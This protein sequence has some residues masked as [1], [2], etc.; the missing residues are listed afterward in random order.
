MNSPLFSVIIPTFNRAHTLTKCIES[1]LHQEF[2]DY[3]LIII[4]DG[5]TDTTSEL[6]ENYKNHPKVKVIH[7]KNHGVSHARNRGIEIGQGDYIAFL[8]SDDFWHDNKLLK[9]SNYIKDNPET[10]ILHC[11]EI[12]IRNDKRVNPKKIHQKAG[13]DQ[14][15][16]SI[17]LCCISPSAVV[18]KKEVL[19]E[20][21]GFNEE[22]PVCED[23]DLW[24]KITNKY[25]VDYQDEALLTKFGGHDDQLSRKYKAMD[26]WRLKSCLTM[27]ELVDSRDKKNKLHE[28]IEK[29]AFILKNGYLKYNKEDSLNNLRDLLKKYEMEE[30]IN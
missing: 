7:Q 18:I 24:L 26:F 2:Q 14:F 27:L 23:Y 6:L 5:S 19:K 30:I 29:R 1:V 20:F 21:N 4:N 3:E 13:G 28:S 16:R 17:E 12:W 15:Y 25:S 8:D 22:Y 9:Q 10:M 11:D